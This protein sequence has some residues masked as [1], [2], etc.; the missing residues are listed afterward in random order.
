[1]CWQVISRNRS[2]QAYRIILATQLLTCVTPVFLTIDYRSLNIGI[3]TLKSLNYEWLQLSLQTNELQ[4]YK[5]ITAPLIQRLIFSAF[6]TYASIQ[7]LLIANLAYLLIT[8]FRERLPLLLPS[9]IFISIY[10]S[11]FANL[12][13]SVQYFSVGLPL[14]FSQVV[15]CVF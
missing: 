8:N 15:F 1:M 12:N 2:P 6:C 10:H 9:Q 14:R 7:Q 11:M 5:K 4:S 3:Q 13:F